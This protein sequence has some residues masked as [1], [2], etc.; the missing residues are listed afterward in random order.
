MLLYMSDSINIFIHTRFAISTV[1]KTA[2]WTKSSLPD[3]SR[4]MTVRFTHSI[5]LVSEAT[6]LAYFSA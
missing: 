1:N 3:L 6:L 5:V 4:L 2:G